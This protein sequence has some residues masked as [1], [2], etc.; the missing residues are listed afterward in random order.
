MS[1]P[2]TNVRHENLEKLKRII[3]VHKTRSVNYNPLT[4]GIRIPIKN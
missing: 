4:G 1:K 3:N 2:F